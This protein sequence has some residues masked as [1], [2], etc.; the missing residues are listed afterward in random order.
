MYA[1]LADYDHAPALNMV[2]DLRSDVWALSL[3][4]VCMGYIRGLNPKP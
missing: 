4:R 3:S 2:P 1:T